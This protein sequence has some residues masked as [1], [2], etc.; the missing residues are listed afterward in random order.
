MPSSIENWFWIYGKRFE[1]IRF[2][3]GTHTHAGMRFSFL[4]ISYC[5]CR[6]RRRCRHC[7]CSCYF[8]LYFIPFACCP[9]CISQTSSSIIVVRLEC[10]IVYKC[11]WF[12]WALAIFATCITQVIILPNGRAHTHTHSENRTKL[13]KGNIYIVFFLYCVSNVRRAPRRSLCFLFCFLHFVFF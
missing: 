4:L 8:F 3:Y 5:F 12:V 9:L 13:S 1:C 7:C 11:I 10:N 6:I 2:N